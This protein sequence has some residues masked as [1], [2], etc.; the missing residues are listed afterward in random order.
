MYVQQY[1]GIINVVFTYFFLINVVFMSILINTYISN[2]FLK[3]K[4][5]LHIKLI[6]NLSVKNYILIVNF[7]LT[8]KDKWAYSVE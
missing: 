7:F 6:I 2:N 1:D 3:K 5:S 8:A 4:Y